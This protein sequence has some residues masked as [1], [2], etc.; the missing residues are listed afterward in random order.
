MDRPLKFLIFIIHG[1][2]GRHLKNGEKNRDISATVWP[3]F[4]KFGNKMQIRSRRRT[5]AILNTVRS[6][7]VMWQWQIG[8]NYNSEITACAVKMLLKIAVSVT[9]CS[10]FKTLHGKSTSMRTTA[11]SFRAPL[12]DH[13]ITRIRRNSQTFNAGPCTILADNLI[14]LYIRAHRCKKRSHKINKH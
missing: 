14:Y 7:R 2:G 6:L 12:T 5:S 10:I 3:M 8:C 11:M 9:K 13:V 1:D 4:T